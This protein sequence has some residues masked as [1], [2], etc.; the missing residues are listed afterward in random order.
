MG[1]ETGS[2]LGNCIISVQLAYRLDGLLF[3]NEEANEMAKQHRLRVLV[4][5]DENK[6]PIIKQL[7]ATSELSLADAVI[8]AVI[9]S[10]R[11]TE[12]MPEIYERQITEAQNEPKVK[13]QMGKYIKHWRKM[14][15][16]QG[17]AR[18]T[19]SFYDAKQKVITDFFG[20]MPIEDMKADDVQCFLFQRSKKY[21][22]KTV[23]DDLAFLRMVLDSAVNDGIIARNIAKDKRLINPAVSG[24]GT[25]ALTREQV[26]T[27]KRDLPNLRDEQERCLLA[28]LVN[29]SMRREE[30]L[31]LKWE[32]VDFVNGFININEALVYS[33]SKPILKDTKTST[34]KRKFPMNR[35]L[36]G[37]LFEVRRENGYVICGNDG[38]PLS[39]YQYLKLWESLSSHIELYG[40]T[41]INFRTTFATMAIASGVDVKSTQALLGHADP[42][43]TL[44]VYAKVEQT[45][46]PTAVSQIDDYLR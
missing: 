20:D 45:K 14:Y 27:I 35:Q 37:I 36:Q 4:G 21:K 24:E 12:F 38:N 22:K 26:A 29:T 18:T 44:R 43:M 23:K 39:L 5:Y 15:K 32:D 1:P 28:L 34:S 6:H 7:A 16:S 13:T 42:T 8:K 25:K 40:A 41:A 31:G 46:L 10:G 11:I 30:A 19:S 9:R 33:N 2:F 3:E 17:I